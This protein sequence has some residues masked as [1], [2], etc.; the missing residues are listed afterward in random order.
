MNKINIF[1]GSDEVFAEATNGLT[2]F[3]YLTDVLEH[4]RKEKLVIA[5]HVPDKPDDPM[6][7]ENLIVHTDDYGGI[8]EWAMLGFTNN[9]LQNLR[10][11][12]YNLWLCN[13]PKQIYQD[14]RRNFSE[15]TI[16]EHPAIYPE[17][18]LNALKKMATEF[19]SH[20]IGQSHVIKTALS[21]IYG[22]RIPSRKRPVTLLFLGDSG[23]GKTATAKFISDCIGKEMVRIQFS[24][25][26]TTTAYQYIFGAE[27]GEDSL[28]RALIRRNSN[29]VLLDEFDK[30]PP[31]FYN[32][33]YQM[34]DE[35]M[36]VDS[37]YSVD[38]SKCVIICTTNYTTEEE[39]EKNLGAPIYSRFS[40]VIKFVPI[41][42]ENKLQIAENCYESVLGDVQEEDRALIVDN[43]ILAFFKE[44]IKNG[45]Y[46]NI[47]M[48]KND[49]ED[50][51]YFEILRKRNIL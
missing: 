9:I 6:K 15:E 38:V 32:A 19:D 23:I 14:I 49:I 40:K 46:P 27:H 10:V 17:I 43:N 18:E 21:A 16:D 35:G 36:F 33:F 7:V 11:D 45:S 20:V 26:Q 30:V 48:L 42:V 8:N 47:R 22:L 37:N 24:M 1:W 12:I 2:D 44:H 34:F 4:I 41:S 13:P 3:N 39:A 28:A 25:Q 5:G 31:A 50:A 51:I 29:V